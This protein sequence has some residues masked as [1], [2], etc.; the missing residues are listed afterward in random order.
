MN[1]LELIDTYYPVVDG[2]I[3]VVKNYADELS[4]VA[5]VC[6]AVPKASKKS[7]Y[8]DNESFKVLRCCSASASEGYRNALPF[9]DCKFKREINKE[10]FDILHAHSPFSLGR[11]AI[12]T[13][14]KKQVPVVATLHTKYHQDFE[15]VL[16]KDSTLVDFM[17]DY[18]MKVFNKADSVWTVSYA[19]RQTL[20]D[21]GY[22]GE[23]D[24]VRNGT[25][26]TYPDNPE[27]L[28]ERVNKLHNL[29]AEENVFIF[30][31]RMAMYKG[32]KTIVDALSIVKNAG[33][34]FKMLFVGGGFDFDTLKNYVAEKGIEK[35][36]ILTGQVS[37]KELIQGYYLRSDAL[38]FPS[39][40]DMASLTKVE[41][42]AH[43]KPSVVVRGS[44]S[45]EGVIDNENGF[46]CDNNAESFAKKIIE[47]CDNKEIVKKI[48]ENAY[49]TLYW[50][51]E[52]VAKEVLEK[53]KFIIEKY[54]IDHKLK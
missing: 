17:I 1:I 34:Q 31:G 10:D 28:I 54:K 41:A 29:Y 30:V 15:R 23:I 46:L 18:I 5:S 45:A 9:L 35:D 51:W 4:K 19:S 25:S 2:A 50:N 32:L 39:T 36:C 6:L 8:V 53:Y 3:G 22:K 49:K 44:C 14:R 26:Y 12:K 24:V 47:L 37:D 52:D 20:I 11:F 42:S 43:K 7:N 38:L 27:E 33:K 13:G 21:Y 40:F 16:G 48:G